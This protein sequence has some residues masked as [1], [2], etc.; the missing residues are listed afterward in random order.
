MA[1]V[2]EQGMTLAQ[3]RERVDDLRRHGMRCPD[4]NYGRQ[5]ADKL[6]RVR[7]AMDPLLGM[8]RELEALR[9]ALTASD[10]QLEKLRAKC[11][12]ITAERDKSQ[13]ALT[14]S[15]AALRRLKKKAAKQEEQA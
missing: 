12:K 1:T 10:D 9:V 4:P 13:D 2:A 8:E 11:K 3:I 5:L 15:E 7:D 6:M 14:K